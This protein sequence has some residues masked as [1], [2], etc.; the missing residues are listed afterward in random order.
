MKRKPA[1]TERPSPPPSTTE[2]AAAQKF[3]RDLLVRGD[4]APLDDKGKL[5]LNATHEIVA[6]DSGGTAGIQRRRFKLF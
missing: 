6:D 4:A 2:D 5:P 1:S 3:T